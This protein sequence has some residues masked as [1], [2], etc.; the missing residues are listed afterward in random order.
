MKKTIKIKTENNK[1][2][3]LNNFYLKRPIFETERIA[4]MHF[5]QINK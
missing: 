5:M 2:E 1:N 3:S 4:K